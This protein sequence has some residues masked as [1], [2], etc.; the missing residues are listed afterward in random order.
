M[1]NIKILIHG[2][3]NI[4]GLVECCINRL[5]KSE[6]QTLKKRWFFMKDVMIATGR[7]RLDREGELY[8]RPENRR[9]QEF[10]EEYNNISGQLSDASGH[11]KAIFDLLEGPDSYSGE[12]TEITLTSGD[13]LVE[14]LKDIINRLEEIKI[15]LQKR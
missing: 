9:E 15:E 6:T 12:N 13:K 4:L 14:L 2:L 10:T 11:Y 7:D 1:E 3:N 8:K 5:K